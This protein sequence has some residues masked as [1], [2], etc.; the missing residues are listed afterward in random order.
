[1]FSR[2]PPPQ[3]IKSFNVWDDMRR[4]HY[5]GK[6]IF[7]HFFLFCL[8]NLSECNTDVIQL[9]IYC[10][11]FNYTTIYTSIVVEQFVESLRYKPEGRGFDYPWSL[12]DFPLT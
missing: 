5:S 9:G 10:S 6:Q 4:R 1:M 3:I 7:L 11:K 8:H 2:L 12:E